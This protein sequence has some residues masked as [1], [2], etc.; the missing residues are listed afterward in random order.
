MLHLLARV[1]SLGVWAP[2]AFA[3]VYAAVVIAMLPAWPLTIVAGAMFGFW[4]GAAAAFAGAVA[5]STA[6][7]LLARHGGRGFV[8]RR[9]ARSPRFAA[10]ELAI[11]REGRRIVFLMRLSP[12][13]PFNV[14]NY[15]LGLTTLRLRDYLVASFGMTPVTV[16]Y[17]YAGFM[18]GEALALSGQAA[19]P[20]TASYYAVLAAGLAASIAATALVTRAARRAIIDV[21]L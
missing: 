16:M 12:F 15:L 19:V 14:G 6:A 1:H 5:G 4:A 9:F 3:G 20:K 2:V 10:L 11:R 17:A 7:F 8:V 18:A 13:V 21:R